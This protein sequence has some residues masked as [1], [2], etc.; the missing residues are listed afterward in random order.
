MPRQLFPKAYIYSGSFQIM[1]PETLRKQ[2]SLS[3]KNVAYVLIPPNRAVNVDTKEDYDFAD[4]L[5][6]KLNRA[7]LYVRRRPERSAAYQVVRENLET[8]LAQRRAGRRGCKMQRS[9]PIP[10][11]RGRKFTPSGMHPASAAKRFSCR[12]LATRRSLL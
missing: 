3:G 11:A 5:I 8:W 4:F 10:R 9:R 6:R 7:A 1:R 12:S 2:K